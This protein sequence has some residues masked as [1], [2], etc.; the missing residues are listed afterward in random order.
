MKKI[1]L[2]MVAILSLTAVQAQESDNKQQAQFRGPRQITP[3]QMADRMANDLKLT[4]EQKTKVLALNKE[5]EKVIAGPQ[6]R[7]PR[8]QRPDGESGATAQN[9]QQRPER[10]QMT[11]EQ[12]EQMQKE[13]Q[14][15]MEQRQEY[16]KKLKEI[17]TEDQY[18]KYQESRPQRRGFGG[19]GRPGGPRRGFGGF[20]D[21]Q[22]VLLK[23][24]IPMVE[25]NYRVIAD[26]EHRALAGLSMGGMQTHMITLA[27]PTTFAYVGM[28]SG[29]TFNT[30]ELKD[31]TDFKKTN[32]VLFMSCGS[33]ENRMGVDKAAEDLR[34]IGINAHS[35]VSPETAHEWQTWRRSLYQFAQLLFK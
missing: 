22:S 12:R 2:T 14:Q 6:M 10:P 25:K 28:F 33:R 31:A 30:D 4:D 24:I 35:Y 16:E 11:E 23:D 7:G 20:S 17:L 13:M 15:R 21:F 1:L 3:E 32:K 9:G 8:P 34:A 18:K 27:N 26:T 29:G 5:Y 19:P